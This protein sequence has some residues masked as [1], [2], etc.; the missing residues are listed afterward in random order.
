MG[1]H[2]GPLL[3]WHAV[4]G[5]LEGRI[6]GTLCPEALPQLLQPLVPPCP[7]A[8]YGDRP[9]LLLETLTGQG[10]KNVLVSVSRL[11]AQ[12]G[13]GSTVSM[14]LL[15]LP[16][17]SLRQDTRTRKAEVWLPQQSPQQEAPARPQG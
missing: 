4:L 17:F 5:Q 11:S 2:A 6:T 13:L 16:L 9:Q 8:G 7:R 10:L 14:P 3:G 1:I 12:R 15:V